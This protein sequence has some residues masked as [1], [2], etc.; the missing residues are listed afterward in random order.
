MEQQSQQSQQQSQQKP[1]K[2]HCQFEGCSRSYLRSEH[3]NRHA[4]IRV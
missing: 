1:A 3:L 4:L 2:F